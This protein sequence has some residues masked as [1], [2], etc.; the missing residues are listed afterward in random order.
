MAVGK[1]LPVGD[2]FLPDGV[3]ALGV[4]HQLIEGLGVGAQVGLVQVSQDL[5]AVYAP[6]EK[7]VVGELV[8][9]V[10]GHFGGQKV[11][12]AAALHD[13]GNGRGVAEG[14]RQPEGVGQV[15]E[16]L[17]GEALAPEELAD[18]GLAGGDVAVA[19]HPDAAVGLIAALLDLFP[20][21]LEKL[22]VVPPDPLA[23]VGGALDELVFRVLLHEA[24]LVCVGPGALFDGDAGGP[25]PGRIHM[26]VADDSRLWGA[27]R[28]PL[29]QSRGHDPLALEKGVFKLLSAD[30]GG[31]V[32]KDLVEGG[33]GVDD[34]RLAIAGVVQDL[35][36]LVQGPEVKEEVGHPVVFD[37][38]LHGFE[39]EGEVGFPGLLKGVAALDVVPGV[40]FQGDV[41]LLAGF[42]VFGDEVAVVVAVFGGEDAE[43]AAVH[44]E[45]GLAV[46]D[47]GPQEQR[48][49]GQLP[50]DLE[51]GLEP[52]VDGLAAPL[53]PDGHGV[54]KALVR[55]LVK[56]LRGLVEGDRKVRHLIEN[57]GL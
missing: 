1:Q 13:L 45:H 8:G 44:P 41:D 25:Q 4:V 23:V 19:L 53:G 7:G 39:G 17:F 30:A 11:L 40:T 21:P 3:G 5:G 36:Q 51:A 43:G 20:D 42:W 47:F 14:V 50:G 2:V 10:P 35:G 6:P 46:S 33:E 12:D 16:V 18:H 49:P 34:L 48:G 24:H 28:G 27:E 31:V 9:I 38:D 52:A 55:N 32:V 22:G 26:G 56:G 29:G 54:E 57:H 37:A 15:A